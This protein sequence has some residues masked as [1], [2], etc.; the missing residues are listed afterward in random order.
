MKR[1]LLTCHGNIC[2]SPMAEMVL[3]H[4]VRERGLQGY[5]IDSAAVSREEI[6]NPVYPPARRE[7]AAHGIRCEDHRARQLLAEDYEQWD[8]LIGM[9]MS[10]I[11]RML[12]ILGGD[13]EHKVHRLMDF[14]A[15]PADVADPW[16]SDRFDI[17]YRDILAGCEALLRFIEG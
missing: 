2:R 12:R 17:C 15:S 7:L 16:Y 13:P 10:N 4:L 9:D 1:I 11:T 5:V 3:K 6:G 8:Y 14:T